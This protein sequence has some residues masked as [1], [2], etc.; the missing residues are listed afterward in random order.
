MAAQH[1]PCLMVDESHYIKRVESARCKKLTELAHDVKIAHLVFIS[2]TPMTRDRHLYPP[3]H[4]L[5]PEFFPRFFYPY[6]GAYRKAQKQGSFDRK[7][8]FGDFFCDGYYKE[9]WM[10]GGVKRF[11]PALNGHSHRNI[12]FQ[13]LREHILIQRKQADVLSEV[14]DLFVANPD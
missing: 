5:H 6:E 7:F 13:I 11:I 4:A 14:C 2:G 8:Y 9:T 12:L 3:L 1:F 10:K